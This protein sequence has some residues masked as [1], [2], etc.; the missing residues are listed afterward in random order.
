MMASRIL[1]TLLLSLAV[2]AGAQERPVPRAPLISVSFEETPMPDVL[3]TFAEFS[4][5]SIVAGSGVEGAVSADI[6]AQPWDVALREILR[7]HGLAA[8]ETESGIIRVDH[9]ANL[10]ERET[11][12]A[13]STRV[14]RL[15]FL[16]ADEALP[17]VQSVLSERGRAA[18]MG[19]INALVVT[20]VGRVLDDV[21]TLLH[22]PGA[23]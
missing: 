1:P 15:S 23:R 11:V 20:D 22:G 12:E 17:V 3:R 14:F 6:R 13:V 5:Y 9:V 2:P 10:V 19:S 8:R 16:R 4:G 7:A 21:A 18:V